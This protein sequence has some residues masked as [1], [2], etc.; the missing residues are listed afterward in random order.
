MAAFSAETVE[1]LVYFLFK[2]GKDFDFKIII[3]LYLNEF[4]CQ[5]FIT[6]KSY[7]LFVSFHENRRNKDADHAPNEGE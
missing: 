1:I 6:I 3:S 2:V 5:L 4:S 7:S